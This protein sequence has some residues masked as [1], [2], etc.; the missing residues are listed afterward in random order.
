MEGYSMRQLDMFTK[1]LREIINNQ[2]KRRINHEVKRYGPRYGYP[3]HRWL[4][5]RELRM[6]LELY[7][8]RHLV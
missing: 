2:V 8:R 5:L 1:E 7:K 6:R 4:Y 3:S